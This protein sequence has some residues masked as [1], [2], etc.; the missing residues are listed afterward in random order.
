MPFFS[1]ITDGKVT[2][3]AKKVIVF[4]NGGH[5]RTI[6]G[7]FFDENVV[8]GF[9]VDDVYVNK[10][11]I[12]GEFSVQPF[13][14]ITELFPPTEYAVLVALGFKDLNQLRKQKTDELRSLGYDLVSFMDR[15]VR[16]PRMYSVGANTIIIGHS[17]I[18]EGVIIREG[19]F[20]SSGAVLG[21]DSV[22]DDYS[23]IGTGAVLT[24]CV[25]VGEFSVLGMNVSVKQNADL[26]H[27]T[28]VSPN[29]FVGMDTPP[30][31]S[32]VSPAGK[33]VAVDS[34]KLHRFAYK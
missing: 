12:I 17:D 19:V 3:C 33:A 6:Y 1:E 23:W 29:T 21:H 30:Y 26:S 16:V 34:R 10:Q 18:H 25:H 32:I 4:G 11:P 28:L 15:S 20:I 22:L 7:Y 5:A 8:D 31:S 2:R 13:S 27:H 14:K 24:G 9:I